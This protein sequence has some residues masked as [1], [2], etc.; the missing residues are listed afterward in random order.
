VRNWFQKNGKFY[1]GEKKA[2]LVTLAQ[3]KSA[4]RPTLALTQP[5]PSALSR[6]KAKTAARPLNLN[7]GSTRPEF[8][9]WHQFFSQDPIGLPDYQV[10]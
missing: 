1:L 2:L 5:T 6:S 3:L 9:S 10:I 7:D 8:D 4:R